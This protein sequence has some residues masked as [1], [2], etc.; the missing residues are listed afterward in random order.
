MGFDHDDLGRD[1]AYCNRLGDNRNLLEI[2][3]NAFVALQNALGE[4]W[5]ELP[6]NQSQPVGQILSAVEKAA[7]EY[8]TWASGQ[9]ENRDEAY[10]RAAARYDGTGEDWR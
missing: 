8:L 1:S 7:G 10:E 9:T 4:L 3:Q 5:D 6:A 2:A